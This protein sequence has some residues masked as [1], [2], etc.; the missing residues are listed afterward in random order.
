MSKRREWR[1]WC[2]VMHDMSGPVYQNG[3]ALIYEGREQARFNAGA[4]YRGASVIP[5]RIVPVAKG[6]TGKRRKRS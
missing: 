4:I 3:K 1:A 6:K 2:L 5:V